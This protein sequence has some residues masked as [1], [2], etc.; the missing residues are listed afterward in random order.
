MLKSKKKNKKKTLR[1]SWSTAA[2][3]YFAR[4][5]QGVTP[6]SLATTTTTTINPVIMV[7]TRTARRMNAPIPPIVSQAQRRRVWQAARETK[8]AGKLVELEGLRLP[9]N[10]NRTRM[11]YD[12]RGRTLEVLAEAKGIGKTLLHLDMALRGGAGI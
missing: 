8:E 6:A 10:T 5:R 1:S 12:L 3:N 7:N 4:N 11:F 2:L 9:G